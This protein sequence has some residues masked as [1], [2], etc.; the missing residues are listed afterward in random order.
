MSEVP[1]TAGGSTGEQAC[2]LWG[3][4]GSVFWGLAAMAV[5]L[6]SQIAIGGVVVQRFGLGADKLSPEQLATHAPVIGVVTIGAVIAPILMIS[7]AVRLA[8]C[9]AADYLGLRMPGWRYLALGV[10]AL[11]VVIPLVD[12]ISWLTGYATTPQFVLDLYRSARDTNSV[13]LLL[14]AICIAAPLVEELVFRGFLLPGFAA[15][16]LGV[17]GALALT[18]AAWAAMH[19]QYH[20][21]YLI[22]I[23]L[24]GIVFGWLRLQSG[25]TLL[26][27][28]LHGLLNLAAFL[29][30]AVIVERLS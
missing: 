10:L 21:F 12:F 13:A 30:A 6:G 22:Q 15:S 7:L 25:S 23:M 8:H 11:A 1:S 9:R 2:R 28:L 19:G 5:W 4:W 17:I 18:A 26:T 16:R 24:L 29:Q 3:F 14:I 27:I 20:P